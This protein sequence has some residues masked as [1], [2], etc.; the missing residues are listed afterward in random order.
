MPFQAHAVN[1]R[2]DAGVEQLHDQHQDGGAGQQRCLL[3]ALAQPECRGH[4]NKGTDD[5][6]AEGWLEPGG[7]QAL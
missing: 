7:L 6:L 4:Q 3:P 2:F 5:F 1:G